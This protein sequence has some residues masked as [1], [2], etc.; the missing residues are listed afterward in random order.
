MHKA[1]SSNY[2]LARPVQIAR[3]CDATYDTEI[4]TRILSTQ[5]RLTPFFLT[6]LPF[7]LAAQIRVG[8]NVQVSS[9]R[10][11]DPHG[12]LVLGA[13]RFHAGHL[14]ACSSVYYLK[15]ERVLYMDVFTSTDGGKSWRLLAD[16]IVGADPTCNFSVDGTPIVVPAGGEGFVSLRYSDA[17]A[18]TNKSSLP[19]TRTSSSDRQ[20]VVSDFSNSKYRGSVYVNSWISERTSESENITAIALWASRDSG[21]TFRLPIR[22]LSVPS[23][24]MWP[25]SPAIITK[26]GYIG[27]TFGEFNDGL[28]AQCTGKPNATLR[29]LVSKDGGESFEKAVRLS[30]LCMDMRQSN[31]NASSFLAAD[32]SDG[33]L[34]GRLYVVW[35]DRRSGHDQIM[36]SSSADSGQHWSRPRVIGNDWPTADKDKRDNFMPRVAVN[37][38]G[39]V[40]V[41]WSDRRN[42]RDNLGYEQRFT[43]SLDGGETWLPSV[44]VSDAPAAWDANQPFTILP[45][46]AFGGSTS[47]SLSI[48]K[49]NFT[50]GD[51]GGL[52]VDA[53]GSFHPLWID[54]RTGVPQI[55][56]ASVTV[57]GVAASSRDPAM[58]SYTDL[59]GKAKVIITEPHFDRKAGTI[60]VVAR[61]KNIS[62]VALTGPFKVELTRLSSDWGTPGVAAADNARRGV[63]SVWD[64]AAA[65]PGG[66]LAADQLSQP[67][68]LVFTLKNVKALSEMDEYEMG[69]FNFDARVLSGSANK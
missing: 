61:I 39:V 31:A 67:K 69:F 8:P 29:Y 64:F 14:I 41:V 33:P 21:R 7:S 25:P 45:Y 62:Q 50:G 10:A 27:M 34:S 35:T 22:H 18:V 11:R 49:F 44:R 17:G 16:S 58:A 5:M 59:T 40:G 51:T 55:W 26:E 48:H 13:D 60:T 37:K 53:D 28:G 43:A 36:F 65:V 30:D 56:T 68:Q 23:R 1:Q 2:L 46:N 24:G 19:A 32:V 54:N 47:Y 15:T 12:E 9:A 6:L 3:R 57:D 4:D 20:Y 52:D 63:G 42:S 66:V 38:V